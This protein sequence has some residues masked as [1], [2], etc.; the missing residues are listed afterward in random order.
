[1]GPVCFSQALRLLVRI[2][3]TSPQNLTD[4]SPAFVLRTCLAF[5]LIRAFQNTEML[6]VQW[7]EISHPTWLRSNI[8]NQASGIEL[9]IL[10]RWLNYAKQRQSTLRSNAINTC[11][12]KEYENK[13]NW[14]L[15]ENKPNLKREVRRQK[16]VFGPVC[17]VPV[18]S[19]KRL[20]CDI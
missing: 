15:D 10:G 7:C 16:S 19:E 12:T 18:W 20:P 9:R 5:L 6:T 2:T 14:T 4:R 17:S 3:Y 13:S 11:S 1:M 8:E